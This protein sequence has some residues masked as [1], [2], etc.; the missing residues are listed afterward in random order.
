MPTWGQLLERIRREAVASGGVVNLDRVRREALA[1]VAQL[2]NRSTVIY[3]TRWM[4]GGGNAQ[5]TSITAL[6]MHSLME[7][8]HGLPGPGLDIILHSPGGS[9]MAAEAIVTYVRQK[10]SDVRVIVPV[11]AMSAATLVSCAANRIVMGKHSF[12]GPV[13]PQLILETPLGPTAVPAHAI[14]KQF[15]EA[16]AA[17]SDPAQF[18][19]WVPMLQQYG[20]ALLVVS[21][22]VMD[23]S[24]ALVE[25]WLRTWM[26]A[27]DPQAAQTAK[28]AAQKLNEHG[29][30]LVHGRFLS[31]DTIRGYGLVVDDL[32]ADQAFQD[33]VLTVFHATMHTFSLNA[34]VAKI[35]ENHLG[36]AYVIQRAVTPPAVIEPQPVSPPAPPPSQPTPPPSL[37]TRL[38]HG[39][40]RVLDRLEQR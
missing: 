5:D 13:D 27:K 24:A 19:A 29:D 35:V 15:E 28:T 26:L 40:R 25:Q 33:A 36:R 22:N 14:R 1:Q 23:L 8:L 21:K 34:G 31:R 17:A 7:V 38:L 32:E 39:A 16:K 9:P 6:D 37:R 12:L 4:Q 2:T 30:H 20:P 3:A 10:F 11:A 18:G